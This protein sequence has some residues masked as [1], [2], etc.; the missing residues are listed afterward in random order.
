MSTL[1]CNGVVIGVSIVARG[2]SWPCHFVC[3]VVLSSVRL[4]CYLMHLYVSLSV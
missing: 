4:C 3:N 1:G 2:S